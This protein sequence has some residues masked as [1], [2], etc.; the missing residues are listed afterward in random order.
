MVSRKWSNQIQIFGFIAIVVAHIVYAGYVLD[1]DITR[2]IMIYAIGSSVLAAISLLAI[3]SRFWSEIGFIVISILTSHIIGEE[4]HTLPYSL[5][6]YML[7]SVGMIIIGSFKLSCW[8]IAIVNVAVFNELITHYEIITQTMRIE[9]YVMLLLF[10]ETMLLAQCLIVMLYQQKV[11]EIEEQNQLLNEAQK[12]KDEFLANMSHE[13]RTPMNAI[14]GM[15]ELIMREEDASE[16]IKEYCFNIQSSGENLLAIINDILDFSKIESGNMNIFYEPYSI[17]SVVQDVANAAM[18]RRGYKEIEIIIDCDPTMP[19]QLVGDVVRNRQILMNLVTNAVKYTKEGTVFISLSCYEKEEMNWLHMEV[20]DTGIGIREEDKGRLFETFTRM[21]TTRNRS[22]EGTG[23]GLPLCKRLTQAMNGTIEIESEYGVGTRVVVDIPQ[24][25]EDVSPFLTIENSESIKVVVYGDWDKYGQKANDYYRIANTNT[26]SGFGVSYRVMLSFSELIKVMERNE[27]THLYT[28]VGEYT[29][30]KDYFERISKRIKVFV[31]YDPQYPVKF[32][33]N[34]HGV[35]LP[36]YSVN[37]AASLNGESFYNQ[38][39]NKKEV[40]IG[41]KAPYARVLVVDDNDV[42]LRVAEGVLR[43]YDVNCILA[44]SGKEAIELLKDQDIDMVFMDHMMP[45]MDGIETTKIIRRIGGEYGKKLPIV[46]LTANAVNDAKEMFKRNGFQD[47]IAK[48]ISMKRVDSV[49]RRWLP[50]TKIELVD[51]ASKKKIPNFD[52]EDLF[53][54]NESGAIE[55][56]SATARKE[57]QE[58]IIGNSTE[59]SDKADFVAMKIDEEI[60]LENMGYQRELFKELLEY[61]LE[62]EAQRKEEINES[63]E[64][65]DWAEY[66]IRV[67]A[68]KGGMRSLG[69]EEL[70]LAAQEQEFAAKE[71]RIEDVLTGHIHLMSEYERGH[72]SIEGFLKTFKV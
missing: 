11:R 47:F 18:F 29:D 65:Q 41:F 3:K 30:Q 58:D 25:I 72:R 1:V 14:V 68:L 13:I 59:Q 38:Y 6:V 71:Q 62:L 70:A 34:I 57:S 10:C 42:N 8:Y 2:K 49:L 23:L 36:F 5:V 43:L 24:E 9:Y 37:L 48:P 33:A 17:A 64:Q 39:I 19:K 63:F 32:G 45:E 40:K 16:K 4:L 15:T 52:V 53:E 55:S 54:D 22:V 31:M 21:D 50:G 28:G 12:S 51:E 61:C 60:A 67:H 20:A 66:A 7:L 35:Q 69:V 27:I 46:A 44:R 26:W 56:A